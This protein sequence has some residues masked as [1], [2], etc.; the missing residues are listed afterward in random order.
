ML[1]SR[2]RSRVEAQL[3]A[4]ELTAADLRRTTHDRALDLDLE[5]TKQA[6]AGGAL[7]ALRRGADLLAAAEA[8]GRWARA[9]AAL[10]REETILTMTEKHEALSVQV[11]RALAEVAR[12]EA[13]ARGEGEAMQAALRSSQ[14]LALEQAERLRAEASQQALQAVASRVTLAQDRAAAIPLLP[15]FPLPLPPGGTG[16]LRPLLRGR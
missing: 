8:V 5:M 14:H 9:A 13:V 7:S 16:C 2:A 15:L 11:A 1:Q 10:R 4:V 3:L 6:R 12:A